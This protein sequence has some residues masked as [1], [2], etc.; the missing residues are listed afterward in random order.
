MTSQNDTPSAPEITPTAS[1][2][3]LPSPRLHRAIDAIASRYPDGAVKREEL[4]RICGSSNS[5]DIILQ[6]RRDYVG[7]DGVICTKVEVIDR[8]GRRCK[9]GQY[10]FSDAGYQRILE[11]GLYHG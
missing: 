11:Q 7:N 9:A 4:D 2:K 10:S 8:D 3:T 5:P 6:L 1:H